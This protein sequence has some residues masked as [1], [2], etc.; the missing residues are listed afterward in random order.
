LGRVGWRW[1]AAA[2]GIVFGIGCSTATK[3]ASGPDGARRADLASD[4]AGDKP[5]QSFDL[6]GDGKPDVW[7]VWVLPSAAQG[8]EQR[9]VLAEKRTDMNFDGRVDQTTYFTKTGDMAREEL[10][11][12]FDGVVDAVDSYEN[13]KLVL[14]E[15][16]F[17]LDGRP[18][19]R[20]VFENGEMV[21][22]ERDE[23]GDGRI[24]T[25]EVY[26]GGRISSVIHDRDGDGRPDPAPAQ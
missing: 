24:E 17:L 13:G 9:K 14:R 10:D 16:S 3:T 18:K 25:W 1:G 23:D 6:N 22:K 5:T 2:L 19:L 12:D 4:L 21:R 8:G 15:M 7:K 11:F 20:K 26:E